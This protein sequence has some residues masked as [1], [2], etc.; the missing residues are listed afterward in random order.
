MNIYTIYKSTNLKNGKS[1]IGFDSDYPQRKLDH[2]YLYI[3]QDTVF[4]RAIRKYGWD[5]FSWEIIYQSKD[6]DHTK[7]IMENYFILEHKTYIHN[8]EIYGYN[9]TLGGEGVFGYVP[10]KESKEKISK[11]KLGIKHKKKRE[12]T[13]KGLKL[14]QINMKINYEKGKEKNYSTENQ[15][16][17]SSYIKNRGWTKKEI[18][19]RSKTRRKSYICISPQGVKYTTNNII[20]FSTQNNLT[21]QNMRS[22]AKGK[23]KH[24]K[25]WLCY[26]I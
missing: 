10:S 14:A 15:E 7:N 4:Y 16:K 21:P 2:K 11:S 20:E 3:K 17:R 5:S 6:K 1:Y 9:M 18:E 23:R 25:N 8:K 19:K 26:E 12:Y 24:H 13:E 22:V